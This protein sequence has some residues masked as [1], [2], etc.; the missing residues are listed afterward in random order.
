MLL[1]APHREEVPPAV[2]RGW[3]ATQ[4]A[5]YRA[6][7]A[8]GYAALHQLLV[9]TLLDVPLVDFDACETF[10]EERLRQGNRVCR[11]SLRSTRRSLRLLLLLDQQWRLAVRILRD[12]VKLQKIILNC[13]MVPRVLVKCALAFLNY[14]T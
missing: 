6:H 7:Q 12:Y 14:I 13:K 3:S 1:D 11:A 9:I 10:G 5:A 8:A 2:Q 4:V